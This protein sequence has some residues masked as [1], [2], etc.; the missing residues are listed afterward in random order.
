ME[1]AMEMASYNR[2]LNGDWK[3]QS[4]CRPSMEEMAM[5][6]FY[7]WKHDTNYGVIEQT[8]L[9]KPL[10]IFQ[11]EQALVTSA[12][13]W[14]GDV[15]GGAGTT[16][17]KLSSRIRHKDVGHGSDFKSMGQR[18]RRRL[19]LPNLRITLGNR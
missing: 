5:E 19:H 16:W 18:I 14:R 1:R 3:H 15:F 10:G 13:V 8:R 12:V 7:G 9:K 11:G 6:T 17:A 4:C 2:H